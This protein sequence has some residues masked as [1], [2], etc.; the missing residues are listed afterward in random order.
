M[1]AINILLTGMLLPLL[2][3]AQTIQFTYDAA[4]NRIIRTVVLPVPPLKTHAEMLLANSLVSNQDEEV[5]IFSEYQPG[6]VEV[7]AYPNP[8]NGPLNIEV[9]NLDRVEDAVITMTDLS[10]RLLLEQVLLQVATVLDLSG[11]TAG[12]YILAFTAG[13]QK[14]QWKIVKQ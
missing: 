1:K 9:L 8:T 6:L 3:N 12:I 13:N 2:C 5:I 7:K 14:S 4:G 10:G 11:Y